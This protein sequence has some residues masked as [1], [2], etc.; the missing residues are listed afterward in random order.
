MILTDDT[1]FFFFSRIIHESGYSE[2]ECIQYKPVVYS[3][4]IQSMLAIIRAM[5]TLNIEFANP[6]RQVSKYFVIFF[7]YLFVYLFACLFIYVLCFLLI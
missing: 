3:N 4:T 7:F 1:F 5:G 2:D 6:E